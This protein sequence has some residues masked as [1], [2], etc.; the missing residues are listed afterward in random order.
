[1]IKQQGC[2]AGRTS[3]SHAVR[4]KRTRRTISPGCEGLETRELLATVAALP[5]TAHVVSTH[6]VVVGSV[7]A[8]EPQNVGHSLTDSSASSADAARPATRAAAF[9]QAVQHVMAQYHV[10]GAVAG[11]W[12]PGRS[13]WMT[14]QGVANVKTAEPMSVR[15]EF[16]IRSV[17]KSFTVTLILQLARAGKLSLA[18]PIGKYLSGVPNGNKITLAELAGMTSG[19]K[20]YEKTQAVYQVLLNDPAHQWTNAQLISAALHEAP[21]FSPGARFDYSNTNTVLLGMVAEEM[22]GRPIAQ[23]Y[24]ARIFRPLGL[25]A[26]SYPDNMQ[27][28]ASTPIGYEVDARSG[29]LEPA[30][31]ANLSAFGPAGGIVSTLPNLLRWGR[32]LGTGRLI[33][34]QLLQRSQQSARPAT[35]GPDYNAYGLGMGTIDGWWGHTGEGLGFQAAAMYD[36]VTRTVVAV[37]LNSSQD[38]NVATE[39]FK[40]LA[41]VVRPA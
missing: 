19:L 9:L 21:L 40:A 11:V 32:A 30:I 7:R 18:D 25:S 23:L 15:D 35:D 3:R 26:T 28:P 27:F 29:A 4:R 2:E 39:I 24:R 17:T 34:A 22:T 13:L 10:P 37:A 38:T 20:S 5:H 33:G 31:I 12:T 16:P 14:A 36:P 8:G 1:M 41:A 6:A